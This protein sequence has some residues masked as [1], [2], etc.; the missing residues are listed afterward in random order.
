MNSQFSHKKSGVGSALGVSSEWDAP[1]TLPLSPSSDVLRVS[2]V[3]PSA[4]DQELK[5]KA[6]HVLATIDY[7]RGQSLSGIEKGL[8]IGVDLP[9]LFPNP[10]LEVWRS[11]APVWCNQVQDIRLA[12]TNEFVFGC[13][14][15][16]EQPG[17]MLEDVARTEYERI[18]D[19]CTQ[20]GYAHLLRMWNY[21]PGI[22]AYQNGLE[23]Y[24]RFC[25]G[26]HQAF[27]TYHQ[28]IA[29]ILPA[30]QCYRHSQWSV[31]GALFGWE[32]TRKTVRESSANQCV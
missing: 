20:S 12:F 28:E 26:R 30:A 21:F 7:G 11:S 10:V 9:Q 27:S 1:S 31:P 8:F 15:V 5:S 13:I 23:R 17:S 29:P 24:K 18:I 4:C 2:Y 16:S 25:V 19:Y 32:A 3:Q 14:E 6:S 22:N